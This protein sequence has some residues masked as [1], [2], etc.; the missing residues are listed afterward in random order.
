MPF[1]DHTIIMIVANPVD[2]LATLAQR[3][4]GLPTTRVIGSGTFLDTM[5]IRASVASLLQ[6]SSSAVHLCVVGE[7]GDSQVPAWSSGALL[8]V[9]PSNFENIDVSQ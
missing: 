8:C 9:L 3:L 2:V 5:R 6:V 4:S 1:A 7:H